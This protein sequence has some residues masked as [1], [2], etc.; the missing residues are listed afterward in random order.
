[1]D[2]FSG[3]AAGLQPGLQQWGERGEKER[4]AKALLNAN[5]PQQQPGDPMAAL[6]ALKG[7]GGGQPGPLPVPQRAGPSPAPPMA[8]PQPAPQP[9][10]QAQPPQAPPPG[11]PTGQPGAEAPT[12]M[13]VA[14]GISDP[15][16]E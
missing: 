16:K 12:G 4:I 5:L 11:A 1:M 10:P 15:V 13:A 3:L 7:G 8:G 14:P 9:Q 6:A 2:F